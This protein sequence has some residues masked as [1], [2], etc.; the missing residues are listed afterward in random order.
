MGLRQLLL[1]ELTCIPQVGAR[2][3]EERDRRQPVDRLG[4]Q[5]ADALGPVQEVSLRRDGHELFYF[6]GGKPEGLCLDFDIRRREL[7]KCVDGGV[8]QLHD[9]KDHHPRGDANDQE[10]ETKARFDN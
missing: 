7:G 8:A 3:E 2:L 10:P 6:F 1:H 4:T 5:H 9:T